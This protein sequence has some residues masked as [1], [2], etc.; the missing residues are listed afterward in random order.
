MEWFKN[1]I[2]SFERILD[3]QPYSIFLFIGGILVIISHISQFANNQAWTFL[4]YAVG[5]TI[6]RYAEKDLVSPLAKYPS[7]TLWIRTTYHIGNLVLFVALLH[8]LNF[9]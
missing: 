5:G 7:S 8:Y 6:W 3:K 9:I 1:L 2:N 4:L